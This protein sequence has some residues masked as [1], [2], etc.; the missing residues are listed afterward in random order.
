MSNKWFIFGSF[1]LS[2]VLAYASGFTVSAVVERQVGLSDT[3]KISEIHE[4]EQTVASTAVSSAKKKNTLRSDTYVRSI[5]QR[6]IFDSSKANI[7]PESTVSE[8]GTSQKSDLQL[9]LLVTI[10]GIPE[11]KSIALIKENTSGISRSYSVGFDLLGE[12]IIT[13]IEK[14][15]VYFKKNNSEE[16]EYIDMNG[17]EPEQKAPT[18]N[19]STPESSDSD[20]QQVSANKYI[21]DQKV[22][23]EIMSNPEKLYSQ[24]RVTPNKNESGEIDGYRMTGIRRNSLFYKLGIKNGDIVHSVNGQ[25]LTSLS[26]AMD[27]YNSLGNS[28]N[29]NFDVTR[30]KNKQTFEY[31]VR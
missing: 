21:V 14:N 9:T 18:E 24:V 11:D 16:I 13:K 31:D 22:L 25:P 19:L 6:S 17:T 23:D 15:R 20:V 27:A 29:F 30:R 28:K 10:V 26:A 5:V 12:A 7:Q 2:T 3:Q 1:G 8:D 4:T